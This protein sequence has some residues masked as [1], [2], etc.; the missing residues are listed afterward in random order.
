MSHPSR[1]SPLEKVAWNTICDLIR[2]ASDSHQHFSLLQIRERFRAIV[3]S[4][5]WLINLHRHILSALQKP[6][7]PLGLGALP[8]ASYAC[9]LCITC[10][11]HIPAF[12][13]ID[14]QT[15]AFLTRLELLLLLTVVGKLVPER[16]KS[17]VSWTVILGC[18]CLGDNND[19]LV[20]IQ[21]GIGVVLVPGFCRLS[22][23]DELLLGTGAHS[24]VQDVSNYFKLLLVS[25]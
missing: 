6:E 23:A 17:I 22:M 1:L 21:K 9:C 18:C 13:G 3:Q 20:S 4:H 11:F 12:P 16:G 7:L 19:G 5:C 10:Y 25:H 14:K 2:S 8:G 15:A 24:T